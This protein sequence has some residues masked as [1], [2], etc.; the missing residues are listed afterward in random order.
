MIAG[1]AILLYYV[2]TEHSKLNN[3][4]SGDL[5]NYLGRISYS[6]YLWH[7]L[8]I[9]I[10]SGVLNALPFKKYNIFA[11]FLLVSVATVIIAHFSYLLLESF[12]FK[13]KP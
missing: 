2:I 13:K 11:G 5:I 9:I 4:L 12:Y 10:L 1:F 8:S 7:S 6:I 3:W